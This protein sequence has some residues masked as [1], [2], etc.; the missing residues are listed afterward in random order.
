MSVVSLIL[1][2]FSSP[3]LSVDISGEA[4]DQNVLEEIEELRHLGLTVT[5]LLEVRELTE[6]VSEEELQT[7]AELL[8]S[9]PEHKVVEL[10]EKSVKELDL[11]FS[12]QWNKS[13]A[14]RRSKRSPSPFGL[15][16][17]ADIRTQHISSQGWSSPGHLQTFPVPQSL[18]Y[19]FPIPAGYYQ[20]H[21]SSGYG[22]YGGA[23]AQPY[24]RGRYGRSV[25]DK[26]V[27]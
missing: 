3:G 11:L 15:S 13:E 9:L 17:T 22:Y 1:I 14:R 26:D 6:T 16:L 27:V 19:G 25:M 7:L 2:L 4:Q 23:G 12:L 8:E 21:S 18:R 10:A 5:D 24:H 20:Q